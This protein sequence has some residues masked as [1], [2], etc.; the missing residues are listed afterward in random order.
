MGQEAH[1]HSHGSSGGMAYMV[2]DSRCSY[3]SGRGGTRGLPVH[4]QQGGSHSR[5]TVKGRGP[6]SLQCMQ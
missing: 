5:G 6:G 4:W 2:R 3:S 1:P